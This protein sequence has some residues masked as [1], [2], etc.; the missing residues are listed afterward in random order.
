MGYVPGRALRAQRLQALLIEWSTGGD[1][2]LAGSQ[3]TAARAEG[4]EV[5]DGPADAATWPII[6]L[7]SLP[8]KLRVADH[9]LL[10]GWGAMP[11]APYVL[12]DEARKGVEGHAVTIGQLPV[13]LRRFY[14]EPGPQLERA[15]DRLNAL[16]VGLEA[17][18]LIVPLEAADRKKRGAPSRFRASRLVTH[19][20]WSTAEGRREGGDRELASGAPPR[21]YDMCTGEDRAEYWET[22]KVLCAGQLP[23]RPKGRQSGL[24][25][26]GATAT[27]V[28]ALHTI[29]VGSGSGSGIAVDHTDR[30]QQVFTFLKD[31]QWSTTRPLTP[32]QKRRLIDRAPATMPETQDELRR[33]ADQLQV[34]ATRTMAQH[35]HMI[36]VP[37]SCGPRASH[38]PAICQ[39]YALAVRC[40]MLPCR[41]R[42][43]AGAS[44]AASG[45]E[46]ALP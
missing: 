6:E 44:S 31:A 12:L 25:H 11:P 33:W 36:L 16:V 22:L 13:S 38:M 46:A 19:H 27:A 18:G 43:C 8:E 26:K 45:L 9:A 23:G 30:E 40:D 32:M 34:R 24:S 42:A 2:M 1:D 28:D 3:P 35:E 17:L 10:C 4:M 20:D 39:P 15:T 5:V 29:T 37:S 41:P 21:T 14:V 7:S